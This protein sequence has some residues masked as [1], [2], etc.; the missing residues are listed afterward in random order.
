MKPHKNLH[1]VTMNEREHDANSCLGFVVFTCEYSTH[2]HVWVGVLT[3]RCTYGGKKI[4]IPRFIPFPQN[5]E[6]SPGCFL[7]HSLSPNQN[8][9]YWLGW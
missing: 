1:M 5:S 3:R 8:L 6:N 9:Q 7:G 4:P 2:V